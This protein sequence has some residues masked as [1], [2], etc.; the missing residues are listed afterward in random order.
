MDYEFD[1]AASSG[2][3]DSKR[4]RNKENDVNSDDEDQ[5][6]VSSG[7]EARDVD[8]VKQDAS[9]SDSDLESGSSSDEEDEEAPG[10]ED[11]SVPAKTYIPRL[12]KKSD[13]LVVDESA[14]VLLCKS[15]TSY[16][17]MSF[18]VINDGL[19]EG[20][21]RS[22]AFP[23]SMSIVGGT[24]SGKRG[25]DSLIVMKYSKLYPGSKNARDENAMLTEQN[26]RAK[27]GATLRYVKIAHPGSVNRVRCK[28]ISEYLSSS[29]F[30][31]K[32]DRSFYDSFFSNFTDDNT[33][34]STWSENGNVYVW[35]LSKAI[36]AI[37]S[38]KLMNSFNAKSV[39]PVFTF[40]GHSKEGFAIDWS[41]ANYMATGD[42]SGKIYT[43]K[44]GESGSWTVGSTPFTGHTGS[45]EDLQWSPTEETI[46][47]SCSTDRSI[48]I[49]DARTVNTSSMIKL[50]D[51][52]TA[53]VNVISWNRL[54]H[55]FLL[56]GG[57][58]G[59][60]KCW[61]LRSLSRAG[62]PAPIATFAHHN[63]PITS[64]EWNPND[65]SV[66]A[67]SS[68]DNSVSIWDLACEKDANQPA[69]EPTEDDTELE[70]LPPQ[71][72]FIHQG[73]K[74]I[75]EV[76]WHSQLP[77]YLISTSLTGFDIFRTISV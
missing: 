41:F 68:E 74:E 9:N 55:P 6:S 19:G 31:F 25:A 7:E 49:W 65:S 8:E 10:E 63:E 59:S 40:K 43:W 16:P 26:S 72:L 34:C 53:D 12:G 76:H 21:D 18:D 62:R 35:E 58:D 27:E 13:N 39:E 67:A 60:I 38:D 33:F 64:I 71:L 24:Y 14:Y 51:A 75:K 32:L 52:H 46:L 42:Q 69:A 45:V 2:E 77:G 30:K 29:N 3:E 4:M 20:E 37:S 56:S 48:R 50:A 28:N 47:A 22:A 61:D 73:Q 11:A 66:F 70:K 15:K 36:K 54:D 57:D 23:I 1:R 44:Q 5:S 17:C